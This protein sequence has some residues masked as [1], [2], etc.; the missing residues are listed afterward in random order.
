MRSGVFT[1]AAVDNIDHNPSSTPAKYLF[2]GTAIS[3]Q[4]YPV[5]PGASIDRSIIRLRESK[6]LN[7]YLTTVHVPFVNSS[8]KNTSVPATN[9]TSL[10]SNNGFK[11]NGKG[12]SQA[13]THPSRSTWA[14]YYA[15]QQDM[16]ANCTTLQ[17][18]WPHGS[19]D[20][21]LHIWGQDCSGTS[22]PKLDSSVHIRPANICFGKENP[23]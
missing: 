15:S 2:Q 6:K 19:N 4:Q 11:E 17:R 12:T 18:E 8:I 13:I 9:V 21:A 23:E 16:L 22:Q 1:A 7:L 20:Q 14:A 3:F 10:S 5:F